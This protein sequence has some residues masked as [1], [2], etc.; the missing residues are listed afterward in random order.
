MATLAGDKYGNCS[1]QVHC[2]MLEES[3]FWVCHLQCSRSSH[4][5][6]VYQNRNRWYDTKGSVSLSNVSRPRIRWWRRYTGMVS[7]CRHCSKRRRIISA[8]PWP[9]SEPDRHVQYVTSHFKAPSTLRNQRS[10]LVW[11]LH[12]STKH[13]IYGQLALITIIQSQSLPHRADFF[14]PH[15]QNVHFLYIPHY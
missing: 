13:A 7:L 4:M 3:Y 1:A 14:W 8:L 11:F 10:L 6:V 12:I 2:R 5:V 9:E 15:Y